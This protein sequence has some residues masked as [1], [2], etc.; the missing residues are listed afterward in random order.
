MGYPAL[1]SPLVLLLLAL[2]LGRLERWLD[3]STPPPPPPRPHR[4]GWRRAPRPVGTTAPP[5]PRAGRR[6]LTRP[7]RTALR[8]RA[9][10]VAPAAPVVPA[11]GRPQRQGT[12]LRRRR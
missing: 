10:V 11:A 8:R 1:L 6:L 7:T 12:R 2:A 3:E 9:T 5:A 4:H